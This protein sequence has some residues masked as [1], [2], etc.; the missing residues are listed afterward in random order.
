MI[1]FKTLYV[2]MAAA[3]KK[4]GKDLLRNKGATIFE[5]TAGYSKA[6]EEGR[7]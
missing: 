4:W 6:V 7:T 5:Y 1:N 2:H 3:A